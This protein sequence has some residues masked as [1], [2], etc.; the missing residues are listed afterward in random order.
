MTLVEVRCYK[1]GRVLLPVDEPPADWSGS[2]SFTR[3]RRCDLPDPSRIADVLLSS[4]RESFALTG[5]IPWRMLRASI[6]KA[7]RTGK[8]VRF[9][10]RVVETGELGGS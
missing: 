10:V 7:Q 1:C 8:T 5:V 2:V 4:G 6:A 9:D 3:C